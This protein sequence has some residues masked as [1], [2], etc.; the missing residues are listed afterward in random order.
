M[1]NGLFTKR[2]AYLLKA[3]C[4]LIMNWIILAL[5]LTAVEIPVVPP[6]EAGLSAP[7]LAEVDKFMENQVA[8]KKIA[9]GIVIVSHDGKIGLFHVY[10][11]RDVE[12]NQPMRTDTIFRI[13]SMSKAITTAAALNLVDAGKIAVDDPVSKYIPNFADLKVAVPSGLRAPTRAMTVRDLMLHMSGL[14]YGAGPDALKEA[15]DR[16]KPLESTDLKEMAEKLAQIPLAFDPG[17]DWTYGVSIDV[18]GRVIEVASGETLD[19]FLRKTIFDPLDMPDTAFNVPPEKLS[20]LA[21]NY[22]RSTG[23]LKAIDV[24][25]KSKYAGKVTFFAGG[26]GLVG[27]ARD[28]L[29]FL[30]MIQNGG[31]LGGHRVLRPETVALMTT[32]QLPKAAF[33]IHFDKVN[34]EGVGF[35]FGFS[36]RH[37]ALRRFDPAGRTSANAAG[38]SAQPQPTTGFARP[39]S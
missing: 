3:G 4:L 2:R 20:R 33:P 29:R 6:P 16:L 18:L 31:E 34:R 9:G 15:A 36:V 19:V 38:E 10:G 25:A 5:R 39:I 23:G 11:Q 26:G 21:A 37:E 1:N 30:T 28:Y 12:A 14:T 24:P 7:K 8:D 13:Y 27:T 32:N 35:G 17:S 22:A